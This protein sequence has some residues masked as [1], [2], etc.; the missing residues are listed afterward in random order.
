MLLPRGRLVTKSLKPCI[1]WFVDELLDLD[2]LLDDF[3]FLCKMSFSDAR[4]EKD[5]SDKG[6]SLREETHVVASS[7]TDDTTVFYNTHKDAV[8]PLTPEDRKKITRKNFW[9]LLSQTWW[10][11]FLIHLDKSTLSQASTMGIFRD[12]KMTKNEYNNLFLV[13]YA[14][15]RAAETKGNHS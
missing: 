14:G 1:S 9:Y 2:A 7:D 15:E 6:S 5:Q 10:I 3:A 11:A 8:G 13:F 4:S 12:V